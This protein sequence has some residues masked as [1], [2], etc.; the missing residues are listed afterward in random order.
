[1]AKYFFPPPFNSAFLYSTYSFKFKTDRVQNRLWLIHLRG[2]GLRGGGR[3]LCVV[4]VSLVDEGVNLEGRVTGV[5][6][7]DVIVGVVRWG[8]AV[9]VVLWEFVAVGVVRCEGVAVGVVRVMGARVTRGA[10][11]IMM[12][13]RVKGVTA[14]VVREMGVVRGLMR[15]VVQ[16]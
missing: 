11:G 5:V 4:G 6:L 13:V 2:N 10:D 12:V 1:M 15:E 16:R 9:G 8:V 3:W 14:G 7:W